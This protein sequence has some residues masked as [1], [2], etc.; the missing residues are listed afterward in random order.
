MSASSPD[1]SLP[2]SRYMDLGRFVSMLDTRGLFFASPDALGDAD[3]G[4]LGAVD[5]RS[6]FEIAKKA[7]PD[8]S[9]TKAFWRWQ[10][11][12]WQPKLRGLAVSSWYSGSVESHAMWQLY[13]H[14]VAI[15]ST[16]GLVRA[17]IR[18]YKP[19]VRTVCYEDFES[20]PSTGLDPIE[21]LSFKRRG[22]EHERE[23]RFFV[24]LSTENQ[25]ALE[26]L[27][28]IRRD[29]DRFIWVSGRA[30][31]FSIRSTGVIAHADLQSLV[32]TIVISPKA[33]IWERDAV[34]AIATKY[35][36]GH[37]R[38]RGSD[39]ANDPYGDLPIP[40]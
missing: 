20:R 15:E 19:E 21:V 6:A 40:N 39:L 27:R 11:D 25:T 5:Q 2:I 32:Q 1:D 23:V 18:H 31:E 36:F 8:D 17:A 33:R 38:I 9:E 13:G 28:S 4:K 12:V 37:D 26:S 24:S 7:Y 16:I 29:H 14:G 30:D 10:A 35:G 3:E 22:Y 34:A